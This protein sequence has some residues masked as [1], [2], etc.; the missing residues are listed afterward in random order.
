MDGKSGSA[1][2]TGSRNVVPQIPVEYDDLYMQQG[3]FMN[4]RDFSQDINKRM[5]MPNRLSVDGKNLHDLEIENL[6]AQ[7]SSSEVAAAEMAI[8]DKITLSGAGT[9]GALEDQYS[10]MSSIAPDNPNYVNIT[11]PPRVLTV[12]ER[13]PVVNEDEDTSMDTSKSLPEY[14]VNDTRPILDISVQQPN[15]E[16]ALLS[17][18]VEQALRER[19]DFLEMREKQRQTRELIFYPLVILYFTYKLASWFVTR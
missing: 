5:K 12:D 7:S 9:R 3:S 1:A 19:L 2:Q 6:R 11:T 15:K 4:Q 16:L 18:D 8:P 17:E 13:F 14:P 10:F